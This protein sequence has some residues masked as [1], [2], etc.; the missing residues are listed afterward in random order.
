MLVVPSLPDGHAVKLLD[1]FVVHS[2]ADA[3]SVEQKH[4]LGIVCHLDTRGQMFTLVLAIMEE[5]K[6]M[7]FLMQVFAIGVAVSVCCKTIALVVVFV[8]DKAKFFL[9]WPCLP[10]K[11]C[12]SITTPNVSGSQDFE[13]VLP[14]HQTCTTMHCYESVVKS[15]K[16]SPNSKKKLQD[17]LLKLGHDFWVAPASDFSDNTN[18]AIFPGVVHQM[19][20]HIF[21]AATAQKSCRWQQQSHG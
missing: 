1:N 20:S 12:C 13:I 10:K 9:M 11:L 15:I 4:G 7:M 18:I 19:T 14:G 8:R 2:T 16:S 3:L 5:H 6:A 17:D 21:V